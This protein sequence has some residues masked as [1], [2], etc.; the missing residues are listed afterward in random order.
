M[1]KFVK[2]ALNLC[3]RSMVSA[4]GCRSFRGFNFEFADLIHEFGKQ[5]IFSIITH[6]V[7]QPGNRTQPHPA[8]IAR[9]TT[10]RGSAILIDC[11]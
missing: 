7:K 5:Q 1:C 11:Y 2:F 8:D 9:C 10:I 6:Y 3:Y 4:N